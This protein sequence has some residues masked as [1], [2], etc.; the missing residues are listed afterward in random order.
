VTA[1]EVLSVWGTAQAQ[2]LIR[3]WDA[4]FRKSHPGVYVDSHLTGSDVG[5]AALYTGFADFAVL[6]REC[7]AFEHKAFEWIFRYPPARIQIM[8][9]SLDRAGQAPALCAY[10]H[11]DNPLLRLTLLQLDAIFGH[12]R[13]SGAPRRLRTW[14]DLGLSREWANR[15]INL[16]ADDAESG[17][18]RFFRHV[19]LGDSAKMNWEQLTEFKGPDASHRVLAALAADPSGLAMTGGSSALVPQVKVLALGRDVGQEAVA[20]SHESLISGRYPMT[21]AVYAYFNRRPGA[22]LNDSVN[23]FLRYILSPEG[24][25]EVVDSRDYLPLSPQTARQQLAAAG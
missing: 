7:T 8:T 21:R 5:M 14:G 12:E 16:Y 9:G 10:V 23:R 11:R 4:G 18:G 20:P 24:Q 25:R 1:A 15:A 2:S 19:V 6:S 3:R 13:L 22:P 17:T